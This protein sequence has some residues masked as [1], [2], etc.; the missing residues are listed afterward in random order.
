MR[1]ASAASSGRNGSEALSRAFSVLVFAFLRGAPAVHPHER[2]N[3]RDCD[4]RADPQKQHKPADEQARRSESRPY[5]D[6]HNC[7]RQNQSRARD[8]RGTPRPGNHPE[9]TL[10]TIQIL[11]KTF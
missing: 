11:S 3:Q 6:R 2:H 7:Q 5:Q 1:R 10:Q 4:G 8:C 9:A